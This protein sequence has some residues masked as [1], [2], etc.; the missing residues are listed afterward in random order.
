NVQPGRGLKIVDELTTGLGGR[1]VQKF[2]TEGSTSILV[3]PLSSE[4]QEQL[5]S[6]STKTLDA[7]TYASE[8]RITPQSPMNADQDWKLTALSLVRN[9]AMA[10]EKEAPTA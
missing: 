8:L 1:F 9:G 7:M 6:P 4:P 2:G 5:V 3:F 10:C